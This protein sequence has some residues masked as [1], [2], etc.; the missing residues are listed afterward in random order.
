MPM[1]RM[2]PDPTISGPTLNDP[3]GNWWA[4]VPGLTDKWGLFNG[5]ARADSANPGI[6]RTMPPGASNMPMGSGP[7]TQEQ[8]ARILAGL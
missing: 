7:P 6:V 3:R 1:P 5:Q 2:L 8:L 4:E